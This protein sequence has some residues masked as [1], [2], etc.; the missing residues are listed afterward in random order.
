MFGTLVDLIDTLKFSKSSD[1]IISTNSTAAV[2]SASTGF[3]R[4]SACRCLG[5]DPELTPIRIGT[6]ASFALTATSA[7]FSR[8]PMLP[9]LSRMQCA[10]ASIAFSASVWLKWMSA[11]TGIGDFST[12][13]FSATAS[14]SRGTAHAH[15]V[16]AGLGDLA[17]LLHRRLEVRRLGLGHR[18]HDDRRTAADRH[19]ADEYLALRSHF[20]R[21]G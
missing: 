19:A 8:P 14:S 5:S 17:D 11:I 16:G 6:P 9:G 15:E 20:P 1:S 13:V 12:I 2:T 18:L 7:T 4:S 21:S 10:P 3:S